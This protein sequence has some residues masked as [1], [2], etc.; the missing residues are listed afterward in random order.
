MRRAENSNAMIGPIALGLV[1][2]LND[3]GFP[4]PSLFFWR[5]S[6]LDE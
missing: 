2:L 1:T 6:P 4:L 3:L 5:E